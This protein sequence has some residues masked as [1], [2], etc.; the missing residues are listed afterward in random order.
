MKEVF[1]NTLRIFRERNAAEDWSQNL[2]DASSGITTDEEW[3]EY[4]R[5]LAYPAGRGRPVQGKSVMNNDAPCTTT[6]PVK[7]TFYPNGTECIIHVQPERED[8][9]DEK[10]SS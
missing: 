6:V 5:F 4:V 1:E 9:E 8:E 10:F 7:E 3:N 2:I